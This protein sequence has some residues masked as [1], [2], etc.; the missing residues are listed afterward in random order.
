MS[1]ICPLCASASI[2]LYTNQLRFEQKASVMRCANCSLIYLDQNSFQFPVDFYETQYH[3]TYLTHIDPEILDPEKHYQKMQKASSIWT[4]RVK[5]MLSGTETVLDIGCSTGH[6][7]MGIKDSAAKVFG[8]ELSRKEVEFCQQKLKLDVDDKP[9]EQR[10]SPESFDLITLIFVLE[11][12]GEPIA[13]L[14]ELKK[15]LKPN[16]K[17]VIVVPNIL[18]PLVSIYDIENFRKFYFCIEHLFYYSPQTLSETLSQAGYSSDPVCLQEYPIT[19]HLNWI[20]CQKPRET[21]SARSNTPEIPLIKETLQNALDQFWQQ[22]NK[23]YQE[24]MVKNGYSDRVFC[25]AKIQN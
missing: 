18:D 20:Y 6:L 23:E 9:L 12:I 17:L 3:Q 21:L 11:H 19:N 25:V 4:N 1:H 13:F 2:S 10:F 24:L 5:E 14:K 7:L 22:T 15:Y 16:G 8:H